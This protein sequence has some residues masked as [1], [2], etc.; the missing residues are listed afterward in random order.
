[1]ALQH[2]LGVGRQTFRKVHVKLHYEIPSLLRVLGERQ[3]LPRYGLPHSWFYDI[4]DL[5]IARFPVYRRHRDRATAQRLE[6]E[7]QEG[8]GISQSVAL[9][10]IE[11][12]TR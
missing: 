11:T 4:R 9:F 2:V 8:G 10:F 1:M 3:P 5:H 12:L 6:S 7:K